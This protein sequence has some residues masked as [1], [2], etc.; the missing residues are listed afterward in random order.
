M[1]KVSSQMARVFFLPSQS[2]RMMATIV[3]GNSAKVVQIKDT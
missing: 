2:T 1:E 3:P